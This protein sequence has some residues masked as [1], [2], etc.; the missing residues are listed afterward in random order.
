MAKFAF[1][2][3]R[4]TELILFNESQILTSH[5]YRFDFFTYDRG[6]FCDPRRNNPVTYRKD[7]NFWTDHLGFSYLVDKYF[8]PSWRQPVFIC[9]VLSYGNDI[10]LLSFIAAIVASISNFLIARKFGKQVVQ[11]LAGVEVV[12]KLEEFGGKFG[13]KTLFFL[14]FVL[15]Q[16]HDVISYASGLTGFAFWPYFLISFFGMLPGTV[17]LY[18]LSAR[19]ND[20][21]AFTFLLVVVANSA[22]LIYY[23][24][25][26]L[27]KKLYNR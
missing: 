18:F 26:K 20:P 8:C 9:R 2:S 24:L 10:V 14:R 12:K 16:Q 22:L 27:R 23:L 21:V 17:L 19:L 6:Q 25:N 1:G 11:N 4:L 15:Y 5:N 13:Y 3:I 7:G